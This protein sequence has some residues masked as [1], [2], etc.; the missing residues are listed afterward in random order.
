MRRRSGLLGAAVGLAAATAGA[1][2]VAD[3]KVSAARRAGHATRHD[4][5]PPAADRVG[6]VMTPDGVALYYEENGP[7][8]ASVTVVAAHGFCL[9]RD[10]FLFQ[11]RAVIE[12]YGTQVRFVSYDHRSHGRSGRGT[13]ATATIDQLG[14]DL[15]LVLDELVPTGRVVVI[16]HSMGG[17]T[18][19]ALAEQR[20]ELFQADGRV[21][22]VVLLSTSTGRLAEVTLGLPAV[23]AR[24]GVV[25]PVV[26]KG[27]QR[28]KGIVEKGRSEAGDILWVFIKRAAFGRH[29]EPGLVEF[30]AQLIAA[31]PVDVIAEFYP[32]LIS[33]DKLVALGNLRH[34]SVAVVCGDR[35]LI[36]PPSHSATMA[37]ALPNAELVTIPDTGH[38]A[39]MERPELVNAPLLRLI[40][41]AL[42]R[43]VVSVPRQRRRRRLS[44]S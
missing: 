8:D 28:Q 26:M 22:G 41:Q 10:D 23:F 31:T 3:R 5:D 20:P 12:V 17:M 9:D 7:S 36:T 14:A 43:A 40:D 6:T 44:E 4:Y 29:V 15:G 30:V 42:T 16:G 2:L 34:T 11:R 1:A 21:A 24:G 32:A 38:Q 37:E 27:M 19:M 25:L 39:L 35:D 33:H 18:I 13:A